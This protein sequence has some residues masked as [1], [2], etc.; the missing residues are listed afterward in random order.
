MILDDGI[1]TILRRADVSVPGAKPAFEY[2]PV[3]QSWYKRISFESEPVRPTPG[4][5]EHRVDARIRILQYAELQ[6]ED[7]CVLQLIT[8]APPAG[9]TIYRITR[10]YHGLDDGDRPVQ[11]SDLSLEVMD[12]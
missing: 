12:P 2:L 7:V 3:Y 4:R 10:A 11:I 5:E 6:D 9:T 1:C 8:G